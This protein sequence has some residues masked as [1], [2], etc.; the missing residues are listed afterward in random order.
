MG[1]VDDQEMRR[2]L[3]EAGKRLEEPPS[4]KTELLQALEDV[5]TFLFLVNPSSP[6][7]ICRAMLAS[8][9]S[10]I[11]HELMSHPDKDVWLLVISSFS[12]I[13]K[14]NSA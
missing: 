9:N 11:N 8:M 12:Q 7:S 2:K 14:D 4:S 3:F 10:L 6:P 13:T 1:D 5:E